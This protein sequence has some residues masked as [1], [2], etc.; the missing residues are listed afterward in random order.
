[1][2]RFLTLGLYD[3]GLDFPGQVPNNAGGRDDVDSGGVLVVR[4]AIFL[5]K[6]IWLDIAT[7]WSVGYG[8]IEV[9]KEQTPAGLT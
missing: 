5:G 1:M 8:K 7:A 6:S 4:G 2:V 3:F 9:V